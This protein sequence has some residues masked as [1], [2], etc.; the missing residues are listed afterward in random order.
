MKMHF[1]PIL[2]LVGGILVMFTASLLMELYRNS[3]MLNKLSKDNLAVLEEREWKNAENVF[4]NGE[5]AVKGSLERGEMEKFIRLL[6]SQ[7]N[8]KGLQE[9]SLFSRDGKVS[10]S[11]DN[12]FMDK[13]LP[14]ELRT[15][16]LGNLQRVTRRTNDSFEIY[17]PQKVQ[18]DCLRCHTTWKENEAG[19]VLFCRFSTESLSQSQQQWAVSLGSMKRNQLIHGVITTLII[20][21]IFGTLATFVVRYQLVAP[22][23]RVM[24]HL[25]GAS[26]EVRSTSDQLTQT[27][28]SL[29]QTSSQQA[30]A[31]EETSASL[32]EL[33]AMTTQNSEGA[34]SANVLAN[35]A[36]QA[37][38]AGTTDMAEMT[39]AMQDIQVASSSIAKIIK[40]VDEIAFQTNLLALNAAVEAARAGEAGMGFAVVAE[41]V[42]TLAKR[43][44]EAAKETAHGIEDTIAKS[45]RG[46]DISARVASNFQQISQKVRQVDELIASIATASKE[47]TAGIGQVDKAV[48]EMDRVTQSNAACAEQSA[49]AA[50]EL[51]AQAEAL[52][53]A[54][55]ELMRLLSGAKNGEAGTAEKAIQ[56]A[57]PPTQSAEPVLA[58]NHPNRFGAQRSKPSGTTARPSGVVV[59][60]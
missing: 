53:E 41:E 29:A 33:L 37:A 19:G 57:A 27:S 54:V 17:Q 43:S 16:L 58:A 11:S 2:W 26:D 24:E 20:V 6:Q 36:R 15:Q 51:H 52:R 10:H 34:Q 9:F 44:A 32:S 59:R 4:L 48:Q 38:D 14:A 25:T 55:G 42:R 21:V 8:I 35:D 39:Q 60:G 45:R 56:P 5:N 47:Q 12:A 30:A 22:L 49:A 28:Q 31:I 7:K 13:P 3:S 1:K 18:A 23:V 50:V 46:V 40:T